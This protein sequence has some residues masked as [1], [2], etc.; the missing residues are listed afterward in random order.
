MKKLLTSILT[1]CLFSVVMAQGDYEAFRFSQIE[2]QGS[3]RYL[4][5]GGAFSA[6]GGEFS[7]INTNPASIG[8]F[9]RHEVSFTPM[10]LSFSN[11]TSRYFGKSSYTQNAKYTLP[12]CGLV[13]SSP[14]ANSNWNYWQFGFGYNRIKDYNNTMRANATATSSIIN[15][16]LPQANGTAYRSLT[17]DAALAW[18]TWLIDTVAGSDNQYYSPFSDAS[19]SH[20]ALVKITGG[21]D[22]M[23]FTFGGNYSDKFYV[24]AAIGIP[25]LK[26]KESITYS[27][28]ATDDSTLAYGVKSFLTNSIQE[29][30]GAGINLKLG[31]IYQP[32]NFLRLGVAFQTPTYFW[33]IRDSYSRNMISYYTNGNNSSTWSYDNSYRFSLTTPLKFNVSAAFLIQKRAFISAEYDF[34]NYSM[35]RLYSDDYDFDTE[36]QNI[37]EKFGTCHTIKVGAEVNLSSNF[38]LRAGYNFKSSPYQNFNSHY[39]ATAHY[40][41]VGFGVRTRFIFFDLAYVMKFSKDSYWIYPDENA[42]FGNL[43]SDSALYPGAISTKGL[44]HRIVATI[45]CKF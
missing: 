9:K 19:L 37:E 28:T 22:E 26:Y 21:M 24:G 5:A 23:S 33:K 35:A 4:G 29:N 34:I 39:N 43:T 2:Y 15:T 14:I 31:V 1:I 36:N 13:I 30:S 6:T 18:S 7:A 20:E 45:G 27:E 11:N 25:I 3:A 32:V 44:S 41:S 17:G 16:I 10:S 38:M 42:G 12:E 40:G 8:L